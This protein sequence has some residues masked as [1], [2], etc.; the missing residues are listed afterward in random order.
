MT[1]QEKV[2]V[3]FSL[4]HTRLLVDDMKASYEFYRDTL[5]LRPKFDATDSVYAEFDCGE[6]TLALFSRTLMY[7]A[8]SPGVDPP[9]RSDRDDMV[10]SFSVA[11]VDKSARELASRGVKLLNQ[12]HD[13]KDWMLRVVH[14][15][16]PD[17]HLIELYENL[18]EV[19]T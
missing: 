2:K 13:Q 18:P 12:P 3:A 4:T 1:Q 14:L 17:G 16:D 5:G 19:G 6:H 7:A 10:L 15:R 9:R 11:S 8:V